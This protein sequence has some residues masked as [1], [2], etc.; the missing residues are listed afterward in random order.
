MAD[1]VLGEFGM[2][3]RIG[4]KVRQQQGLAYYAYCN[5]SPRQDRSVW[6]ARAGV[7]P[8]NIELA[9]DSIRSVVSDAIANGFSE[10]EVSGTI[11]LLTGRLALGMETNAGIASILLQIEEFGLGL[12]YVE[13][14]PGLI[15]AVTPEMARDAIAAYLDPGQFRVAIARPG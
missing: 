7:D 9:I 1:A 6:S 10:D 4:D 14:Y 11:R 15:G 12:D 13:R 3:G 8:A 5:T 2:M